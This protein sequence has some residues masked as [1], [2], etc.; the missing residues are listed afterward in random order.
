MNLE[1]SL[2]SIETAHRF[3]VLLCE[4][5]VESKREIEGDVKREDGSF[6]RRHDA[7][8][9][10][11]NMLEKLDFLL[12]RSRRTLNDLRS[13]RRLMFEERK[14]ARV[15]LAIAPVATLP[16]PKAQAPVAATKRRALSARLEVTPK[17]GGRSQIM[18]WYLRPDA[19]AGVSLKRAA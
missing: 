6:P 10:V 15:A 7:L 12:T 16:A 2:D 5:V 1:L 14:A 3:V 8:Q 4:A 18:P 13:L 19:R 17:Q 11:L 9:L